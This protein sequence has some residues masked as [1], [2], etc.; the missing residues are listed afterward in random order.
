MLAQSNANKVRAAVSSAGP[1]SVKNLRIV[2]S[3]LGNR[4]RRFPTT[5]A[6]GRWFSDY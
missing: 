5:W 1:Q 4:F 6:R 2:V 3:S